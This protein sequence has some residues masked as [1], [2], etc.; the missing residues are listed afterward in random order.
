M[1]VRSLLLV[2][3]SAIF[4]IRINAS[5]TKMALPTIGEEFGL[6]EGHAGWVISGYLLVSAIGIPLYGRL[7][8]VYGVTKAFPLGLAAFSAGSIVP[9]LATLVT[10]RVVSKRQAFTRS[11]VQG[12]SCRSDIL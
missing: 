8:G 1:P 9:N 4:V 12:S 5:T 6:S 7:N 2:A 3:V 10:R 11:S